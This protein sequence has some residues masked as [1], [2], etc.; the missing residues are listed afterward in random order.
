YIAILDDD[1]EPAADWL[2]NLY[3]ALHRYHADAVFGS[4]VPIFETNPPDWISKRKVFYWRDEKA[5]SG[6]ILEKGATNNVLLKKEYVD[7]FKLRFDPIFAMSGGCDEDFFRGFKSAVQKNL[8]RD[9]LYV[10]SAEAVVTEYIPTDRCSI[11]YI[12]KRH[13]LEGKALVTILRKEHNYPLLI[14]R[15]IQSVVSLPVYGLIVLLL[16]LADKGLR[17]TMLFK[18][19]F[20]LGVLLEIF[21]FSPYKDRQSIGLQGK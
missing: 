21:Y 5:L 7:R 17:A 19:Y 20:H 10:A 6:A 3:V 11:D 9:G 16:S 18:W 15:F 2:L 4:V 14:K 12:K 8:G 1:E 13:L